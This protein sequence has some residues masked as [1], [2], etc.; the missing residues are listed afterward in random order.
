MKTTIFN[1]FPF[2]S[3]SSCSSIFFIFVSC[4][5]FWFFFIYLLFALFSPFFT[6]IALAIMARY[7]RVRI[8]R[9]LIQ[10]LDEHGFPD[11]AFAL[12]DCPY[13]PQLPLNLK[14]QVALRAHRFDRAL[15]LLQQEQKHNAGVICMYVWCMYVCMCG[16]NNYSPFY[17]LSRITAVI[18]HICRTFL[19]FFWY[20]NEIS[21]TGH[22]LH[23]LW[24]IRG[25]TS[26]L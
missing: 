14:F 2:Y 17:Y 13:E 24:S 18:H 1:I 25:G 9:A 10:K 5:T 19:C 7:D 15:A 21:R 3:S 11:L 6:N 12:F 26:V 4:V 8:T 22:D 20:F 16:V 23:T